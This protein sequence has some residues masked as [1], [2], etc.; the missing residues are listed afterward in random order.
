MKRVLLT[1]ATGFIG[2][3][4]L[5]FLSA[6]GA[7]VHAVSLR[8][9]PQ[10]CSEVSWHQADL[11]DWAQTSELIRTVKPTHLLH[12]AWTV[13]PGEFWTSKDN[14]RWVQASLFLLHAF[15]ESGGQ[16]VVMAGTCAEYDWRYGYCSETVT[17]LM[18]STPYGI[19]KKALQEM[20]EAFGKQAGL[21][22][23]WGRIF[24]LYGPDEHANR[25]IPFVIRSVICGDQ[26]PCSH[27]NQIRDYLF[28]KD[29]AEAFISLL[30]S[31]VRGPVNIGSGCAVSLKS[32][33]YEIADKLGGHDLIKLGARSTP[34]DDPNLLVADVTRLTKEV[35]WVPKH[36]LEQGLEQTVNWWKQRLNIQQGSKEKG[37]Q[38]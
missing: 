17:P 38:K 36:E 11:L 14:F 6:S 1:G 9:K 29:V 2:R 32:M 5:P 22:T 12:L 24:F 4:C 10:E 26:V 7:E 27:G 35:G 28:V 16:R 25:L 31:E 23:A 34:P 8:S 19:C 3:Q 15:A 13:V 18:P 33:I 21:S 30:N 37:V 20:L